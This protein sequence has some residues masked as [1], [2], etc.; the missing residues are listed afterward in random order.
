MSRGRISDLVYYFSHLQTVL[1]GN[2][3]LKVKGGRSAYERCK[4][5]ET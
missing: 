5:R 3:A 4:V 1:K 2:I